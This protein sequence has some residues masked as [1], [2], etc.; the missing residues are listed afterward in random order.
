MKWKAWLLYL[1]VDDLKIVIGME[2]FNQVHVFLLSTMNSLSIIDGSMTSMV[3]AERSKT[4]DKML[5]AMQFK[6][7]F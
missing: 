5:S 4:A 1:E 3:P 6:K 2:F 7:A